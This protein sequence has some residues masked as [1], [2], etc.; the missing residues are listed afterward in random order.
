MKKIKDNVI[1]FL[2]FGGIVGM[3]YL[4]AEMVY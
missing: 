1:G 4:I 3:L 2:M